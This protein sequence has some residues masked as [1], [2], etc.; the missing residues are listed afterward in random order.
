MVVTRGDYMVVTTIEGT[1][2]NRDFRS[3]S[4]WYVENESRAFCHDQDLGIAINLR[5][6]AVL[7][8]TS[9]ILYKDL[10]TKMTGYNRED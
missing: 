5:L 6:Q 10:E 3:F 1:R 4:R 9:I 7:R 2:K 8:F